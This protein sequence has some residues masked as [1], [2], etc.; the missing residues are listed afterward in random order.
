MNKWINQRCCTFRVSHVRDTKVTP[1][2]QGYED[3]EMK[4]GKHIR[5]KNSQWWPLLVFRTDITLKAQFAE[6]DFTNHSYCSPLRANCCLGFLDALMLH[7][8][9]LTMGDIDYLRSPE[10]MVRK[11]RPL[12]LRFIRRTHHTHI[13]L[14]LI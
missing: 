14:T 13:S 7:L 2:S 5:Q 3:Y 8:V 11:E 10:L 1:T 4:H 6:Q 9:S 12:L